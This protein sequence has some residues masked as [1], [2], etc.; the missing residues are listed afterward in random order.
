MA[1]I[2]RKSAAMHGRRLSRSL[3][4]L[5]TGMLAAIALGLVLGVGGAFAQQLR[6]YEHSGEAF[7][8]TGSTAGT[9]TSSLDRLDYD[10]ES[11]WL[12]VLDG[13]NGGVLSRFDRTGAAA[14]FS[15]PSRNGESS[16]VVG[17]LGSTPAVTVDNSTAPSQGNVYV[18][19]QGQSRVYGFAP[20]G[21]ALP[22][23]PI[24]NLSLPC[25]VALDSQGDLWVSE[26][27]A[28]PKGLREFTSA[29]VPTGKTFPEP[30]N[31]CNAAID[32]Q[33]N[34]YISQF[35]SR[36]RKYSPSGKFLFDLNAI[37]TEDIAIDPTNDDV[38]VVENQNTIK[39]FNSRGALQVQFGEASGLF[40][41]LQ[42]ARGV[43][44]DPVTKDVW[45]SHRR[46]YPGGVRQ[47]ERFVQGAPMTVPTVLTEGVELPS[48]NKAIVNG[49]VN[50]DGLP[51]TACKI[52]WGT[53]VN[54]GNSGAC[55]VSGVDTEILAGS[56]DQPVSREIEGL[57]EGTLYYARVSAQ[58]ANDGSRSGGTI[59]FRA[60][61]KATIAGETIGDVTADSAT[62]K[63]VIDPNGG[64][65]GYYVE[66][67]PTNAYGSRY[68]ATEELSISSFLAPEAFNT[69]V[70][71]LASGTEYHYRVVITNDAGTTLGPDHVFKTYS[72]G[73]G[74]DPCPNAQVRQQTLASQLLDCRAYELVSA[75]N[76]GGYDVE[77]SLIPGQEPLATP[78]GADDRALYSIHAGTVPGVSGNPTN[79]GRDP[80]VAERGPSG[81]TTRYV[82]LPANGM[83]QQGPFGSPLLGTDGGLDVF[84]F[85]GQNICSPCFPDGSTNVPLRLSDGSLTKGMAG[86]SNPAADPAGYVGEPFSADGSH[87]VFGSTEK[88][89]E[90]GNVGSV[91]IYDRNLTTSQ[92]QVISTLPGG[93][94]MTGTVGQ[95]AIS[96]DGS[97]ALVATRVGAPDAAG[98]TYWHPYMHIGTN[99][100]SVD[101]AP[102][103]TSG[104][105]FA[106]MTSDG[107]SVFYTTIDK[108]VIAD[109]D[110]G[111]DLY[112]ATVDGAGS[113]SLTLLS[114]GAP[115]P[116]GNSNTCDP[117]A[118]PDGNN[119]NAVGGAS[120][121]GC[122]VV[123]IAGGGGVAK[124][125]RTAYFLSPEKLDGQGVNDAPNLFVARPGQAPRFVATLE[126][127]NDLVRDA[128]ADGEVRRPGDFQLTP[129]GNVAVFV[130]ANDLTGFDTAGFSQVYRYDYVADQID[131]VS[132]PPSLATPTN[133]AELTEFGSSVS[134]DG[135]VFFTSPAPLVL[136]DSNQRPDAYEWSGGAVELIS[137]GNSPFD[138]RLLS[139]SSDG[140]NVFFFTHDTLSFQ[141]ENGN[142]V[143]VYSARENG[144]Y[145]FDPLPFDCVA[146]DECHGP[147][148]AVAD[149]PVITTV[150]PSNVP[151]GRKAK[152]CKKRFV[153][154][155]GKCVKRPRKKSGKKRHKPSRSGSAR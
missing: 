21:A 85:G 6:P 148:S 99:P 129:D 100:S 47:V 111:A 46:E 71:D 13:G 98:N 66:Y 84:A 108:L 106:G 19:A 132:C 8:G 41:G 88:F 77:S 78:A 103:S 25:G 135:R 52:E 42:T 144:G 89:E 22:G 65:T 58:N 17:E 67:G 80:Y 38:F 23:F 75:A 79:F 36:T 154:K 55:Q 119:W 151:S 50:P 51:T 40:L 62:L 33:G 61:S 28:V 153:R 92:T 115:P 27:E 14:P 105:L 113:V 74:A 94:T 35:N 155:R 31:P 96:T 57:T 116:V 139:V 12:Y 124:D 101:V 90:A 43:A 70:P 143:K 142:T 91:S 9:F 109:T 15:A 53:T 76:T 16:I 7:D 126:A 68:P 2:R 136:R 152:P 1:I 104:V 141:D 145:L 18:V 110:A 97:R 107:S 45:V 81:W 60:S 20:S 125:S 121:D 34:F 56:T 146:S 82:G 26:R 149:P 10:A 30:N 128:V 63:G 122:G 133:G 29:G 32:S 118:N 69:V 83:T 120:P 123:P 131:C 130:S 49:I 11:E 114:T 3:R 87:F 134:D 95:L 72:P 24:K 4:Q 48:V 150:T 112:E 140:K 59:T 64:T 37:R 147:G 102:G 44:L 137:T 86:S 54:F 73:S 117:D 138:S 93:A 5:M 127:D 39:Q